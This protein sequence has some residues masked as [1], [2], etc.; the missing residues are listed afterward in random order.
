MTN[1]SLPV[2][3]RLKTQNTDGV[4]GGVLQSEEEKAFEQGQ[5]PQ[6]EKSPENPQRLLRNGAAEKK[7]P[8]YR[9]HR[10]SRG[11]SGIR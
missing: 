1:E 10:K 8:K 4:I 7:V 9:I 5:E 11:G 6:T 2:I 3:W